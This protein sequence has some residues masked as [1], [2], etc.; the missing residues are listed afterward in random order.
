MTEDLE[1]IA[2]AYAQLSKHV[3]YR[4]SDLNPAQLKAIRDDIAR[5]K[6]ILKARKAKARLTKARKL[7]EH[8]SLHNPSSIRNTPPPAIS[9]PSSPVE[10]IRSDGF[11]SWKEMAAEP[12]PQRI[13]K[14][15]VL[16]RWQRIQ[17]QNAEIKQAAMAQGQQRYKERFNGHTPEEEKE[18]ALARSKALG[19]IYQS[20]T[21]KILKAALERINQEFGEKGDKYRHLLSVIT[22]TS[23]RRDE[24]LLR[25][26]NECTVNA[27][28]EADVLE[29]DVDQKVVKATLAHVLCRMHGQKSPLP[30]EQ[31]TDAKDSWN[32]A[33]AV[34]QEVN[35]SKDHKET[36]HRA[37]TKARSLGTPYIP[38]EKGIRREF[39]KQKQRRF[40]VIDAEWAP[41]PV[42][43]DTDGGVSP[44]H[45]PELPIRLFS[46]Y[47]GEKFRDHE[48]VDDFIEAEFVPENNGAYMFAL[49]GGRADFPVLFDF[50]KQRLE[51][52][53]AD[54]SRSNL[55]WQISLLRK[56][57]RNFCMIVRKGYY[58]EKTGKW[59]TKNT[60]T[61]I[62]FLV[63]V[64]KSLEEIGQK[65]NIDKGVGDLGRNHLEDTYHCSEFSDLDEEE[66]EKFYANA[67]LNV[68]IEYNRT[69]LKILYA[70]VDS[71]ETT[72]LRLGGSLNLT[73]SSTSLHIGRRMYL[74]EDIDTDPDINRRIEDAY[75]GGR[76]EVFRTSLD[77]GWY[78]DI[79]S[80]YPFSFNRALPG[81]WT[82]TTADARTIPK[83]V[84]ERDKEGRLIGVRFATPIIV[85]ATVTVPNSEKLLDV[86]K[87]REKRLF[88]N[89]AFNRERRLAVPPLPFK[90]VDK[91]NEQHLFYPTGTW[92]S[93]FSG[94]DIEALIEASVED[95]ESLIKMEGKTLVDALGSVLRFHEVM[96]FEPVTDFREYM[97]D[98]YS[99]RK[100]AKARK[101]EAETAWL[102]LISNGFYGKLG[103]GE[104][105]EEDIVGWDDEAA[106]AESDNLNYTIRNG[107]LVRDLAG[108]AKE[109]LPIE[110]GEGRSLKKPGR[111]AGNA[112]PGSRLGM[113][114]N[115][116][117][118]GPNHWRRNVL[119]HVPHRHLP[120]ASYIVGD[121]RKRLWRFAQASEDLAYLDT[122][123]V[124]SATRHPD[125]DDLGDLKTE[126]AIGYEGHPCVYA[127]EKCYKIWARKIEKGEASNEPASREKNRRLKL[128][129]E[130]L[131]DPGEWAKLQK[132]LGVREGRRPQNQEEWIKLKTVFE[133]E[134][135]TVYGKK[136]F[137]LPNE[138][139]NE[140]QYRK[141]LEK[142]PVREKPAAILKY[143]G[144]NRINE[145]QWDHLVAG[146]VLPDK[147]P[148]N[149]SEWKRLK[150]HY[151]EAQRFLHGNV[152][153]ELPNIIN[154]KD[155]EETE[156]KSIL[157]LHRVLQRRNASISD[158]LRSDKNY[159]HEILFYKRTHERE[160]PKRCARAD[161][162]TV[163]WTVEQIERQFN[164][165]PVE[166]KQTA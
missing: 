109:R 101:D 30:L 88:P 54:K 3:E 44:I 58:N 73:G 56:G 113:T 117:R 2:E 84:A 112:P 45:G 98:I 128:P 41:I 81:C 85:N 154:L 53:N 137:V 138:V 140:Q 8:S 61:L 161:G 96:H 129:L 63:F 70:A 11:P 75:V 67:P 34:V 52:E 57:G 93:W 43:M 51:V 89:R 74:R 48:S 60:W 99:L 59:K 100:Q 55:Q 165:K 92:R 139:P 10:T 6:D 157:K 66:K 71:Y 94:P 26:V 134:Q 9:T 31:P 115:V 90:V 162:T 114:L 155:P 163:P 130:P 32:D 116:K 7:K 24:N 83:L 18:L 80:S 105:R 156:Y 82:R 21:Q 65:L 102:K 152:L 111:K 69:D 149:Q 106:F 40:I 72:V 25:Y 159:H 27:I 87:E 42:R 16:E 144:V 142:N 13:V 79:N 126:Y 121:A 158:K 1:Y 95:I 151:E 97:E 141:L 15:Q 110:V 33:E 133:D 148:N 143:K 91:Q 145:K 35:Q 5:G 131:A 77:H 125:G 4:L 19:F 124:Q 14:E 17:S 50:M 146:A 127:A 166:K 62:D 76:T 136:L 164:A 39:T 86:T 64:Q 36:L 103:E 104:E 118:L 29:E 28:R 132:R 122:D 22:D 120:M 38:W 37:F 135:V 153:F 68:L 119:V 47:D 147:R 107:R 46:A 12:I 78:Q 23:K 49:N 123:S 108:W 160:M 20:A 150:I